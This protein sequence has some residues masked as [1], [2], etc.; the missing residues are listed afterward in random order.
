MYERSLPW[1]ATPGGRGL[2]SPALPWLCGQWHLLLGDR[3]PLCWQPAVET[4]NMRPRHCEGCQEPLAVQRQDEHEPHPFLAVPWTNDNRIWV[5]LGKFLGSAIHWQKEFGQLQD[6]K[7]DAVCGRWTRSTWF[8][9]EPIPSVFYLS[10]L[11]R[12]L[13]AAKWLNSEARAPDGKAYRK[14]F[15]SNSFHPLRGTDS[16]TLSPCFIV[17]INSCPTMLFS[18]ILC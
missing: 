11:P 3:G 4:S 7:E 14:H 1:T 15:Y 12:Q 6:P 17:F 5:L 18:F 13:T 10:S 8:R 16:L 9:Y 2:G